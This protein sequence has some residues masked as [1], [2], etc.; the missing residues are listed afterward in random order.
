MSLPWE[1]FRGHLLDESKTRMQKTFESWNV[2]VQPAEGGPSEPLLAVLVAPSER[3]IHVTRSIFSYVQEPYVT[4]ENVVLTRE[5]RKWV[6]ELVATIDLTATGGRWPTSTRPQHPAARALERELGHVLLLAVIGT[7]RLPVTS[8]ESPLPGFSLGR[9]GY[10]P[11]AVASGAPIT[12]AKELIE[13]GLTIETPPLE[14]AKLL[15]MILRTVHANELGEL[16]ERFLEQWQSLGWTNADLTAMLKTLFNHLALTPYTQ[17][18]DRLIDLLRE[19]AQPERLGVE[20]IVDLLSYMLRYL[21]RHLTAFDLITFHNQGA[22]FP[23]ALMVDSLLRAYLQRIERHSDL[24]QPR[25]GDSQP[26]DRRKRLR[27]RALRQGWLIRKECEGH[28]VPDVPTSPGE[29]RRVLPEPFNRV[30]DP[31]L[32]DPLKRRRTLFRGQPAEQMLSDR[33]RG[34][35]QISIDDLAATRCWIGDRQPATE[36]PMSPDHGATNEAVVIP[37]TVELRELGMALYLDRPLGVYREPAEVDRTPLLSYEAFSLKIAESRLQRLCG[38]PPGKGAGGHAP[39]RSQVEVR[40]L[41]KRLQKAAPTDQGFPVSQFTAA[42]RL[43]S[44]GL[45]D[46]QRAAADFQI[47][48]TTPVSFRQFLGYFELDRLKARFPEVSEWLHTV[49]EVLAIREPHAVEARAAG[50]IIK[51]VLTIF[52]QWL[53]RRLVLGMRVPTGTSKRLSASNLYVEIAGIDL[54]VDGLWVLTVW[55]RD[56]DHDGQRHDL[57]QEPVQLFP[58]LWF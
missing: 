54:P 8:V 44:V 12:T 16:A 21:A 19:L 23:D 49:H 6:R 47:L 32:A 26:V 18:V 29:N 40:Q 35:L 28:R 27:R 14:R 22:N 37:A 7:S 33:T 42:P 25:T 45:E 48:R 31:Q 2:L 3:V 51:S 1:V 39:I 52:D 15:E 11:N 5:I 50:F 13:R 55:T 24:F 41:V 46:A 20:E 56:G 43:G 17:F 9:Y 36:L 30:P 10:F 53:Q 58:R 38:V 57:T 4:Q 34:V